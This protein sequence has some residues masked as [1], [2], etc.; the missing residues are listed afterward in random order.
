MKKVVV[1]GGGTG[2]IAV[3]SG[4]KDRV[5]IDLSVIVSMTDDGGSNAIVRDEFGLLPL[6]DL[7]KSIIA[8][9][10][11]GNDTLRQLFTYRF[12][13]GD[14][15]SGHTLGNLIMMALCDLRGGEVDAIDAL[16][17]LFSLKG[18]VIPVTLDQTQLVAKYMDGTE[19]KSEHLIDEPQHDGSRKISSLRLEPLAKAHDKAVQAIVDADYIIA[20]PGDLYT[21]TIANIVI[22][23]IPQ[24]IVEST[25]KFIFI[26]N[27]IEKH[28]QTDDMGL[29]EM[30]DVIEQY[31]GRMPDVVVAH[32]GDFPVYALEKYI[33]MGRKPTK[34]D[35]QEDK[36]VVVRADVVADEV[37]KKDHGD[38]LL[39]SLV[40]HDGQKLGRVLCDIMK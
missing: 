3:L 38:T 19:I 23:G 20:G 30:V 14:G 33:E 27:L 9:A 1:I 39:R 10:S 15:L 12:A 25:G 32:K 4:L 11:E 2:T 17:E 35:L 34:D 7:R 22:D 31:S 24:A 16:S 6:S 13:K 40:R 26:T 5:D 37:V 21:T 28:G 18:K 8:L 29:T 36:Y